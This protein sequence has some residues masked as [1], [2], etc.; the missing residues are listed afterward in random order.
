MKTGN[1]FR[2]HDASWYSLRNSKPLNIMKEHELDN[3][4][5]RYFVGGTVYT[6]NSGTV[7]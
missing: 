3:L 4:A 1:P 2:K 5:A 6:C 7:N